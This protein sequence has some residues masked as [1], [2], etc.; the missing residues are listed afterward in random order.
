[1]RRSGSRACSSI[2]S[3]L[4]GKKEGTGCMERLKKLKGGY[5]SSPITVFLLYQM[6]LP[7]LLAQ[8]DTDYME[9]VKGCF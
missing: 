8:K 1:M 4:K 3:I 9:S 7:C 6:N 2:Q 5:V